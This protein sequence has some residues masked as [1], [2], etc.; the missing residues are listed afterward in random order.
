MPRMCCLEGPGG[1]ANQES[2]LVL[3]M[4]GKDQG[5]GAFLSYVCFNGNWM[6]SFVH[7]L[8]S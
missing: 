3:Q 8:D 7:S 2:R 6:L 4:C 5:P 1:D